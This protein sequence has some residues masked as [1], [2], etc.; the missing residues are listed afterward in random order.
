MNTTTIKNVLQKYL[1][2]M[3]DLQITNYL[4][5]VWDQD[6]VSDAREI[7]VDDVRSQLDY[8]LQSSSHLET[9]LD[10]IIESWIENLFEVKNEISKWLKFD[11]LKLWMVVFS[12]SLRTRFIV[13]EKKNRKVYLKDV[14]KYAEWKRSCYY[15]DHEIDDNFFHIS[16]LR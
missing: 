1:W 16:V 3:T 7:Y 9:S 2:K 8:Y 12:E 5:R 11:D 4:N 6:I 14:T 10:S 13:W 15:A